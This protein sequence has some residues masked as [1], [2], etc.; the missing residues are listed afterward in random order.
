M[1]KSYQS[2]KPAISFPASVPKVMKTKVLTSKQDKG[3]RPPGNNKPGYSHGGA[4]K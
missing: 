1:S 4:K 2:S 3:P